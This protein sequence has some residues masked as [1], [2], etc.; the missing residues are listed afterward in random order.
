MPK[1]LD[2]AT[3]RGQQD[4]IRDGARAS[5][6]SSFPTPCQAWGGHVGGGPRT[7]RWNVKGDATSKPG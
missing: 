2:L 7:A 3:L 5:A 6:P 1:L 4:R